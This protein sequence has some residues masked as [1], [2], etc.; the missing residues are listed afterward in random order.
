MYALTINST[1][2]KDIVTQFYASFK[3]LVFLFIKFCSLIP[4]N[5]FPSYHNTDSLTLIIMHH[6]VQHRT[7]CQVFNMVKVSKM[8][9]LF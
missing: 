9:W 4:H 5:G 6:I 2:S 1:H 7:E 8:L 3:K